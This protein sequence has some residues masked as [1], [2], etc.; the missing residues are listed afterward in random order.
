MSAVIQV[1]VEVETPLQ[2]ARISISSW[3]VRGGDEPGLF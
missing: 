3:H 1:R 2:S